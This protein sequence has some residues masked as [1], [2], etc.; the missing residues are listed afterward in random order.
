MNFKLYFYHLDFFMP[1]MVKKE[2][3]VK[4]IMYFINNP[5]FVRLNRV[6]FVISKYLLDKYFHG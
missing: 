5:H 4:N 1:F 2:V 6:Y 3:L